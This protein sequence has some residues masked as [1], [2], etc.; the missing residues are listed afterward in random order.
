MEIDSAAVRVF[1]DEDTCSTR[2]IK[3]HAVQ[4]LEMEFNGE[5]FTIQTDRWAFDNLEELCEQ[6]AKVYNKLPKK[7]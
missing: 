5:Y 7:V 3:V 4:Y 6:L 2:D 1:Q